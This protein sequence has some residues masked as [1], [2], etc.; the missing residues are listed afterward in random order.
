LPNFFEPFKDTH[1]ISGKYYYEAQ[2]ILCAAEAQGAGSGNPKFK[3]QGSHRGDL[4]G[5]RL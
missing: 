3:T 2:K 5:F 1:E 4:I